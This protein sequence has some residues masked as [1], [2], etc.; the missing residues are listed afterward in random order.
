MIIAVN[1]IFLSKILKHLQ[2][3]KLFQFILETYG[4]MKIFQ[5]S[6][7]NQQIELRIQEILVAEGINTSLSQIRCHW[8]VIGQFAIMQK[9]IIKKLFMIYSQHLI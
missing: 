7:T 5:I 4:K 8:E 2:A 1:T 9:R 6:W 3:I